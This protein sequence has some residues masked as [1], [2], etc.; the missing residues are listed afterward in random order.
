MHDGQKRFKDF[1]QLHAHGVLVDGLKLTGLVDGADEEFQATSEVIHPLANNLEFLLRAYCQFA[2]F[3]VLLE[4]I[5][6]EGL[7]VCK[8]GSFFLF[9]VGQ[10]MGGIGRSPSLNEKAASVATCSVSNRITNEAS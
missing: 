5:V 9:G 6:T 8:A 4:E 2:R 10:A 1:E 3:R 7:E